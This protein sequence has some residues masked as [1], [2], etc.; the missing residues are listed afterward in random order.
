M[1]TLVGMTLCLV[2]EVAGC[3]QWVYL[4]GGVGRVGDGGHG[5]HGDVGRHVSGIALGRGRWCALR[6]FPR[7][8]EVVEKTLHHLAEHS[9]VT[10]LSNEAVEAEGAS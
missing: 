6:R 2:R 10:G 3:Q 4:W 7:L 1:V 8:V 5:G 9:S